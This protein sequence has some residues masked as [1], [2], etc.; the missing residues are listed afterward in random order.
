MSDFAV[1]SKAVDA[2]TKSSKFL[3]PRLAS[4]TPVRQEFCFPF[5]MPGTFKLYVLRRRIRPKS[6]HSG[7]F[8]MVKITVSNPQCRSFGSGTMA[9]R[10]SLRQLCFEQILATARVTTDPFQQSFFP[11]ARLPYLQPFEDA[12][13]R[14]SRLSGNI[15]LRNYHHGLRCEA[16]S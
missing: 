6:P 13:E 9:R 15:S 7:S 8:L 2:E 12:N 10:A 14:V 3:Q 11:M 16:A 5:C 4:V 1:A